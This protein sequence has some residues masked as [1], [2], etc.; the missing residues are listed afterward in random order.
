MLEGVRDFIVPAA[1]AHERWF[2]PE[3]PPGGYA[4]P[5]FYLTLNPFTIGAIAV[6]AAFALIGFIIDRRYE[7]TALYERIEAKIRPYRDYAAGVLA[8]AT[9]IVLLWSAKQGVLLA[10]NFPL[11]PGAASSVLR[12]AE[13]A[14]G[15]LLLIGLFTPAAAVGLLALWVAAV[16]LHGGLAIDYVNFVG[17][18]IFLFTFS[19]GRF[20]LDWFLGKPIFTTA[21]MRKRAYFALRVLTGLTFLWLG[22]I[23]LLRPDLHFALMDQ[24]PNFNPYV[25]LQWFGIHMSREAYVFQ[26]FVVETAVGVF[27]AAGFLTRIVSV[28]LVPIFIGS[29]FF[30]GAGE[31]IGH[32]PILATLFVL[33]VYGDTY[34]KGRAPHKGEHDPAM[35]KKPAL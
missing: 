32:I 4:T 27:E 1:Q 22:F 20:S 8:V 28:L 31:L 18:A 35:E 24:F 26:L 29:I 17:I 19:R 3:M 34:H 33:F 10:P 9:A 12:A 11:P 15:M 13:A 6:V 25:I 23:K 30:L 7:K 14:I 5:D 16:V 21:T 2:V